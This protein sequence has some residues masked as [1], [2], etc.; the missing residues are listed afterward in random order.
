M[1]VIL[2]W[3]HAKTPFF[4]SVTPLARTPKSSSSSKQFSQLAVMKLICWPWKTGPGN[5]FPLVPFQLWNND[6]HF[7]FSQLL[8]VSI[9]FIFL[10]CYWQSESNNGKESESALG[11]SYLF[12]IIPLEKETRFVDFSNQ[13]P[14]ASAPPQRHRQKKGKNCWADFWQMLVNEKHSS[15]GKSLH[16]LQRV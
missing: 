6:W 13:K 14:F 2:R 8:H 1:K 10:R 16:A 11:E 5:T 7:T 3:V 4:R 12:Y 9:K 15:R